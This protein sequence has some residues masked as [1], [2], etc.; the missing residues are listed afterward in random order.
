MFCCY[1]NHAVNIKAITIIK[2]IV[3]VNSENILLSYYS[4]FYYNF[5][6]LSQVSV[7]LKSK[8]VM[9]GYNVTNCLGLVVTHFYHSI[10]FKQIHRVIMSNMNSN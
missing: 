10:Y 9:L 5:K 6:T 1:Q 8:K 7:I 2:L 4:V 3:S